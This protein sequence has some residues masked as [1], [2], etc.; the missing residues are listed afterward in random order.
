MESKKSVFYSYVSKLYVLICFKVVFV[1]ISIFAN[2]YYRLCFPLFYDNLVKM[3]LVIRN[4]GGLWFWE[5][6]SKR[7]TCFNLKIFEKF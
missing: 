1:N 3:V 7:G 2:Y 5:S 6:I 4:Q